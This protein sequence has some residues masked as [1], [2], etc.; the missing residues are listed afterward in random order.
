VTG[1]VSETR[2]RTGPE[3]LNIAP[4]VYGSAGVDL[5]D[6]AELFHE[7]SKLS[8]RMVEHRWPGAR[9][10]TTSAQVRAT[11]T[12]AVKRHPS[13]RRIPLPA[14]GVGKARLDTALRARRSGRSFGAEPLAR[15]DVG[16][17]LRAAYGVTDDASDV[18]QTFRSVPS[19]GALYPLDVYPVIRRVRGAAPGTYHF[20]PLAESLEVLANE[21]PQPPLGRL[22]AYPDLFDGA[23][24]VFLIA[25]MFWRTRFKYGLRG[26]RFALLEA[27]HLAQ[28]MLLTATALG[29]VAVPV[30]GFFDRLVDEFVGLDGVN[31]SVLYAVSVGSEPDP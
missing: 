17:L 31:E 19:G 25:A 5:D 26:Y 3:T 12:R 10:L 22:T 18:P 24:V 8:P 21:G 30:G 13:A 2:A 9:L 6:P 29:L 15:R 23:G 20:D 16:T 14:G 11:A 28:N 1:S 27:G 7:A 4:F